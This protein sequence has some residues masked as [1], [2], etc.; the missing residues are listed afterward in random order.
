MAEM[1][2]ATLWTKYVAEAKVM[3]S[4]FIT[5]V[6]IF[7]WYYVL[8][9]IITDIHDVSLI[10]SYALGCGIGTMVC[11]SLPSYGKVIKRLLNNKRSRS[12]KPR[13]AIARV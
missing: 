2:I 12:K 1:M 8:E 9:T 3:A 6:N 11:L 4:T 5:M 7:I 10:F 13:V